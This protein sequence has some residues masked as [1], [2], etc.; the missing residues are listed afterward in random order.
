MN[1]LAHCLLSEPGAAFRI[2]N[3][4]PDLVPREELKRLPPAFASGLACH[5]RIDRFTDAHPVVRRSIGRLRPELRRFGGIAVDLFY[6]HFLAADWPRYCDLPFDVF[7]RDIYGSFAL[8]RADIPP[9]AFEVM[10]RMA[11]E[12]WLGSYQTSAG[13]RQALTRIGARLRRPTDL[14]VCVVDLETHYEK[15]QADFDDFFPELRAHIVPGLSC[16]AKH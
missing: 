5:H 7:L 9:G 1:W 11:A 4:L 10:Q 12:D 3:L 13:V 16:G 8:H 15:F 14:G 2:G 6:D